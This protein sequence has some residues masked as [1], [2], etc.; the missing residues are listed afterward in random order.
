LLGKTVLIMAEQI[1]PVIKKLMPVE[2]V[3]RQTPTGYE[4]KKR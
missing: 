1:Y 4:T 3:G 2:S